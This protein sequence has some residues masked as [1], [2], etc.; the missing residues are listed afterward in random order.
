[1]VSVDQSCG[2]VVSGGNVWRPVGGRHGMVFGHI[3]Q[4]LVTTKP[5][6]TSQPTQQPGTANKHGKITYTNLFLPPA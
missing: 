5:V 2:G 6:V 4:P 3:V 1:M